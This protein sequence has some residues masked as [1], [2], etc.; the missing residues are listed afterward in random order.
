MCNESE[1]PE[2]LIAKYIVEL[3]REDPIKLTQYVLS[4][5][6]QD[7]YKANVGTFTFSQNMD[8]DGK[9][10]NVK[11]VGKIKEL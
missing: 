5:I 4:V 8:L 1:I 6:A 11:I 2:E 7:I 9:R 10:I 3:M